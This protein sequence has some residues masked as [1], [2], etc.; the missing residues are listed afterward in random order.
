M[1]QPFELIIFDNDG[2]LVDSEPIAADVISGLLA[3]H[4]HPM[5]PERAMAVFTGSSMARVREIV[6]TD[7]V[8]PLPRDFEERYYERLFARFRVELGPVDSVSEALLRITT[9][10][11]VASSGPHER[12]RLS[13]EMTGLYHHFEGA[14]YSADD[15]A[16]GKPAPD[17][18]LHA[19]ASMGVAPDRCAVIEDSPIGIEAANAAGMTSFGFAG[20]T[21]ERRL[22]AARGGVFRR[23]RQLPLLLAT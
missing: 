8:D 10:K 21:P 5:S 18:F 12:I 6:E 1:A 16:R 19:A 13:L 23:M 17:L 15:V 11:C 2:V 14:I 3:E 20:R 4:G 9:L 7:A 22:A